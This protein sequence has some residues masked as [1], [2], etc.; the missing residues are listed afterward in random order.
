[1]Q[2]A[3]I[4]ET[5]VPPFFSPHDMAGFL[6]IAK[7]GVIAARHPEAIVLGADTIVAVGDVAYNKAATPEAAREM[8]KT[9]GGARQEVLTGVALLV[10]GHEP[11]AGVERSVV[12]MRPM[13]D[14]ELDAYIASGQWVGKAGAYGIQDHDPQNDPFVRLVEGE[15]SNVVGLPMER[16][17]ELLEDAGVRPTR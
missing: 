6:A 11:I 1:V 16:V 17:R 12:Q 2:P 13:S 9:L 5:D 4:D 8:L 7:A 15:M 14:A 10:P 3:D